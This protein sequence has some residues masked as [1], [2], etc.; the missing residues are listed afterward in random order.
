ME[1]R[2][3]AEIANQLEEWPLGDLRDAGEAVTALLEHPGWT[4][5]DELLTI[6]HDRGVQR[7]KAERTPLGQAEYAQQLGFLN[8]LGCA[9]DAV[10]T[11]QEKAREA[12]Q[13]LIE[14][15][16]DASAERTP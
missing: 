12:V 7:L 9:A 1:G 15:E 10:R 5:V 8:G 14:A 2:R 3:S 16:R 11:V 13:H 4:V 6:V